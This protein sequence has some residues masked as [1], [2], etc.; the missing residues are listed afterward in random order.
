[1]MTTSFFLA[2]CLKLRMVEDGKPRKNG[3]K[4][5]WRTVL[6][7]W[8]QEER[9]LLMNENLKEPKEIRNEKSEGLF[10]DKQFTA[11]K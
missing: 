7:P 3:K 2:F 11:R 4:Y 9:F 10:Y 6:Q 5:H 1:M 8:K